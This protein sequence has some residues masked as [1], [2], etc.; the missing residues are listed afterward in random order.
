M[1]RVLLADDQLLPRSGFRE[2]LDLEDDIEVVAEAAD[3]EQCLALVVRHLPDVALIDIQTP[4][5][6]GIEAT[7]R[8]AADPALEARTGNSQSDGIARAHARTWPTQPP[9]RRRLRGRRARYLHPDVH[10]ITAAGAALGPLQRAARTALTAEPH[11][12]DPL[13]R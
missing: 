3:G 9:T 13:T 10:K 12:H 2:L 8:I 7:G 11:R 5:M 4:L 6:D 1:I